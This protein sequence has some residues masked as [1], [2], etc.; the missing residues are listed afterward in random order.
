MHINIDKADIH[1][2]V[3]IP[4]YLLWAEWAD[5]EET[6]VF[7]PGSGDTLLLNPLGAFLLQ[8]IQ[9]ENRSTPT[10]IHL[11]AQHFNL[12]E[13]SETARTINTSLRTFERMGLISPAKP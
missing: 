7:H 6:A 9:T 8:T 12:S 2:K 13:D 11:A 5:E 10:L 1:W 3:N 4:E